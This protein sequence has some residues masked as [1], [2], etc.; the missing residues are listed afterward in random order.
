MHCPVQVWPLQTP[1]VASHLQ[2]GSLAGQAQASG[3]GAPPPPVDPHL[4]W[5]SPARQVQAAMGVPP[6]PVVP[7]PVVLP[8]PVVTGPELQ[9]P[10][11]HEMLQIWPAGHSVSGLPA[12]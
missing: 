11:P 12:L 4:Q 9:P 8:P 3:G 5:G 10:P 2:L 7:P 1:V 6:L